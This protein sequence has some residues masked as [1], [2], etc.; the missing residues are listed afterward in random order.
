MMTMGEDIP[1]LQVFARKS[2]GGAPAY[3]ILFQLLVASLMLFTRSF[4]AVLDFIQ[5]ALLF[6]FVLHRARRHQAAHHEARPAAAVPRLGLPGHAGG[7]LLVT[8]FM[9]YY[10]AVGRPLQSFSVS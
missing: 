5:F 1:A 8:L 4:E 9:M 2:S 7:F 3:A 6:Y 10:L